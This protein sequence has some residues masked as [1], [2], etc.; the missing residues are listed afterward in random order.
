LYFAKNPKALKP[1]QG[2]VVPGLVSP[3]DNFKSFDVIPAGKSEFVVRG[4][5][6]TEQDCTIHSVLPH[7]HMLGKSVKV[8][9]TPPDGTER[10][11][12]DIPEWDYNWQE[13]YFFK[14]PIRVKAG[15]VF[16]VRAVF[17]NSARNPNNPNSP[18]KDVKRGQQT[19]DEMLF[20]FIR[21]TSDVP[22]PL[23][24]V[25]HLTDPKDYAAGPR[26]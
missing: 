26:P 9:M 13:S 8:T 11:L 22:G 16:E 2:L 20:G 7:M 1:L 6:V 15:T 3:T 17:D 5:V 4:R 18:P 25:K 14:E 23:I 12:V 24:K 19:T 10:V 21:A